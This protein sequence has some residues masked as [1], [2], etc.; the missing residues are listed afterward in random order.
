MISKGA[1]VN[2]QDKN[3]ETP[4]HQASLRGLEQS[5]VMLANT[6][7][8]N[9]NL[10]DMYVLLVWLVF[11]VIL[12]ESFHLRHGETCLHFAARA[13]HVRMAEILLTMGADFSISG[14]NGNCLKVAEN[15]GHFQLIEFFRGM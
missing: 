4:L 11:V 7:S 3:G 14:K 12:I 9:L 5:V 13:G 8:V 1:D 10:L 6:Q 2:S 15:E